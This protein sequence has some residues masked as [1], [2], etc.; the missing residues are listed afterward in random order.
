MGNKL[1]N[2]TVCPTQ[3]Y[4]QNLP[5]QNLYSWIY[6]VCHLNCR[7]SLQWDGCKCNDLAFYSPMKIFFSESFSHWNIIPTV[8]ISIR[9]NLWGDGTKTDTAGTFFPLVC[10]HFLKLPLNS[11]TKNNEEAALAAKAQKSGNVRKRAR[12]WWSWG[13]LKTNAT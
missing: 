11:S 5:I 7:F 4:S 2:E 13:E 10:F 12:A 6:R 3:W 9:I 8:C 1:R